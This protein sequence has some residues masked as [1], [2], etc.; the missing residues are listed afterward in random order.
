MRSIGSGC[1]ANRPAQEEQARE[2]PAASGDNT[3]HLELCRCRRLRIARRHVFFRTLLL[4][5]GLTS[6]RL[7][8]QEDHRALFGRVGQDAAGRQRLSRFGIVSH[9]RN[10]GAPPQKTRGDGCLAHGRE[11]GYM[12]NAMEGRN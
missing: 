7:S 11:A 3:G 2:G 5:H 4:A 1:S 6:E 9:A 12:E 10:I 8:A